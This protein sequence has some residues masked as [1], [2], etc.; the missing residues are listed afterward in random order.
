MLS[1]LLN[2][3]GLWYAVLI[4]VPVALFLFVLIGVACTSLPSVGLGAVPLECP[5]C[6]AESPSCEAK[7][8]KCGKSFREEA[9]GARPVIN[10]PKI[11]A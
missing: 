5:H 11:P 8:T 4:G 3:P 10:S 2:I 7:C 1:F 9:P 6:G